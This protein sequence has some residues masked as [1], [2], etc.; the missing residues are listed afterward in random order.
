MKIEFIDRGSGDKPPIFGGVIV[1]LFEDSRIKQKLR[2]RGAQFFNGEAAARLESFFIESAKFF[3]EVLPHHFE[4]IA[5]EIF[6]ENLRIK[7]L[8]L[9]GFVLHG[10]TTDGKILKK[11]WA[12]EKKPQVYLLDDSSIN[13]E[14]VSEESDYVAAYKYKDNLSLAW[15]ITAETHSKLW[16]KDE[17]EEFR[18]FYPA[19]TKDIYSDNA[20]ESPRSGFPEIPADFRSEADDVNLDNLIIQ[21]FPNT[22]SSILNVSK[23]DEFGTVGYSFNQHKIKP[24]IEKQVLNTVDS[25]G[26]RV[27]ELMEKFTITE[28]EANQLVEVHRLIVVNRILKQG[29]TA[30]R[31]K[32][33]TILQDALSSIRE[34]AIGLAAVD[35]SG[36]END[37]FANDIKRKGIRLCA[38][39]ITQPLESH[40]RSSK[41]Q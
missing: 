36:V 7:V 14:R 15:N 23:S 11:I 12:T 20:T 34:E 17:P 39:T 6:Y 40:S 1:N 16:T 26:E 32:V 9:D 19:I 4:L 30:F 10:N 2:L 18:S 28:F 13:L 37:V 22:E 41:R 21:E 33:E 8:R 27:R 24:I 31:Q 25:S 5:V 29:L 3:G 38:T 35:L